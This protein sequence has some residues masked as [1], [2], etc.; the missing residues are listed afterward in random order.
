MRS[1]TFILLLS[2]HFGFFAQNK[3]IQGKVLNSK[4]G[5][6]LAFANV[7]FDN[8]HGTTTGFNG[9]FSL[10]ISARQP[11]TFTVSYIGYQTRKIQIVP[12]KSYYEIKLEPENEA[13]DEVVLTTK[14]ENPALKIIRKLI[15]NKKNN[16]YRKILKKAAFTSYYKFLVTVNRDSMNCSIDTIRFMHEG[17]TRTIID[18]SKYKTC[19]ELKDKEL[20]L[21][22]NITRNFLNNGKLSHK[23]EA[24]KIAG[25]KNPLYE[26]L[27]LQFTDVEVYDDYYLFL[28]NKYLGPVSKLSFKQYKYKIDDTLSIQNRKVFKINY[29]NTKK[30]LIAGSI[31][32]DSETF[33][34]ARMTLNSFKTIEFKSTQNFKYYPEYK[35]WFPEKNFI[36]IKKAKGTKSILLGNKGKIDFSG[37]KDK[38]KVTHTNPQNIDDLMYVEITKKYFD[39]NLNPKNIEKPIYSLQVDDDAAKKN[40]SFWQNYRTIKS[41]EKGTYKYMDSVFTAEKANEH[42]MKIRKVINGYYPI[43]FFDFEYPKLINY[44]QYE[45]FRLQ[46]GGRTNENLSDK[47]YIQT[48]VAYGFH[49]K[50]F[51]YDLKTYYKLSHKHQTYIG[52][53]YKHDLNKD[54]KFEYFGSQTGLITENQI[55]YKYYTFKDEFKFNF[56][57]LLSSR[58]LMNLDFYHTQ[59]STKYPIP[60]HYGRIEFQDYDITGIAG[61]FIWEPRSKFMLSDFG[62]KKI[63][64]KFPKFLIK[65]EGNI[66]DLQTNNRQ[67]LKSEVQAIFRKNYRNLNYTDLALQLGGS[68][69]NPRLAQLFQPDFNDYGSGKFWKR[70]NI[71][72]NYRFETVKDLEFANNFLATAHLSHRFNQ[73][74]ISEKYKIDMRLTAAYA[75][76]FARDENRY[77]GIQDLRYGLAETGLEFYKLFGSMGL[78][79][80]YR[81][82][83]YA[84]P[85]PLENLSVRITL[86]PFNL[87]SIK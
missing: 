16:D 83:T 11:K 22:E 1:F 81:W 43:G 73:I 71:S 46:I 41:R 31:Y 4:T 67:F 59:N 65:I 61:K 64:D 45:R 18:S 52:I 35:V 74:K 9:E 47:F 40:E 42:L 3:S 79:F 33:A 75:W 85:D 84:H 69:L 56:H 24:V 20:Y 36:T 15:E 38:T 13:L 5:E 44:N 63:E 87:F 17:K 12:G 19:I 49:D 26:I 14:V 68:I 21:M 30:P 57:T 50:S 53:G 23:V 80:Y 8:K 54:S 6:T 66:P 28:F 55:A 32:I 72:D 78:G 70:I 76:G 25:L 82:G 48:Y 51:K 60:Y 7:Y 2:I 34:I 62:R 29:K 27:Q 77:V 39:I 10:E 58:L 86:T 37:P